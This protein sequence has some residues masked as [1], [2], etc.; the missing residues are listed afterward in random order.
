MA[1]SDVTAELPQ[2][3]N[4]WAAVVAGVTAAVGVAAAANAEALSSISLLDPIRRGI[5]PYNQWALLAG[6]AAITGFAAML[7]ADFMIL[8]RWAGEITRFSP[9]D[10]PSGWV[11]RAY[12]HCLAR[13]TTGNRSTIDEVRH[14]IRARCDEYIQAVSG[15][16]L[17]KYY[18]LAFAVPSAGFCVAILNWRISGP[19]FPVAEVLWPVSGATLGVGAVLVAALLFARRV[20]QDL[21]V[22]REKTITTA[23]KLVVGSGGTTDRAAT[24]RPTVPDRAPTTDRSDRERTVERQDRERT[25]ERQ[26][27]GP[28]PAEPVGR[29][30]N[31]TR[32]EEAAPPRPPRPSPVVERPQ[33]ETRPPADEGGPRRPPAPPP[34]PPP[35]P[36]PP[37]ADPDDWGGYFNKS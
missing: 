9:P 16:W 34:A 4:W 19:T 20:K 30:R 5:G 10:L 36:P 35:P 23:N 7:V 3:R 32:A 29:Q 25:A 22:W 17:F 13:A 6:V 21:L 33:Y 18:L 11:E 1:E 24:S 28:E 31:T 8:S 2:V 37:A 14:Q 27:A 26:D 15:A 12:N